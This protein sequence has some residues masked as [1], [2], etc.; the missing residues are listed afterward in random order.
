MTCGTFTPASCC[1][2]AEPT[3][4]KQEAGPRWH[5]HHRVY[6]HP[7]SGWQKEAANAFANAMEQ[8]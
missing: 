2:T 8:G 6:G 1:K 7:L 5:K 3:P 4:S